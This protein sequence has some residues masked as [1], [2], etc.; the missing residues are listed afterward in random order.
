LGGDEQIIASNRLA[1][2]FETGAE[3]AVH[4]ISGVFEGES[5]QGLEHGLDLSRETGR[6]FFGNRRGIRDQLRSGRDRDHATALPRIGAARQV[7]ER[8]DAAGTHHRDTRYARRR[9]GG[10]LRG[11]VAARPG[12][13]SSARSAAARRDARH[14]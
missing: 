6:S 2:L 11:G 12:R 4:A 8:T 13:L 7:A 1:F 14:R 10:G 9:S 5:L 3:N